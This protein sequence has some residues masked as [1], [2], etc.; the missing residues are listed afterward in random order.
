MTS[1]TSGSYVSVE[2]PRRMGPFLL[3]RHLASGGMG[4]VYLAHQ[5]LGVV[6]R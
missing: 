2:L 4:E 6:E 5:S 1:S 3:L